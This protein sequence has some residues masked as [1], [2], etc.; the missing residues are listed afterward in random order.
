MNRDRGELSTAARYLVA[1]R[2]VDV[3][4]RPDDGNGIPLQGYAAGASRVADRAI[5]PLQL[6]AMLVEDSWNNKLLI[7]AGDVFGFSDAVVRRIRKEA[8]RWGIPPERVILNASHTHYGPGT[9]E[10]VSPGL[11]PYLPQYA[12]LI[13][14]AVSQLLP[15]LYRELAPARCFTAVADSQLGVCRRL[16][17]GDAVRMQSNPDGYYHR[18]TPILVFESLGTKA[19][20]V[21]INHGCHPTTLRAA[22]V[23]FA[24]FPYVVRS[25][26]EDRDEVERCLFLQGAAGT[27]WLRPDS[28]DGTA[29]VD[30]RLIVRASERLAEEVEAVMDAPMTEVRGPISGDLAV[31]DLPLQELPDSGRLEEWASS[32]G[33]GPGTISDARSHWAA[34]LLDSPRSE[35]PETMS[36]EVGYVEIGRQV[37]MVTMSAE[38]SA[39]LA[40]SISDALGSADPFVLGYTNGLEG[41]VT[42]AAEI[43]E[44]GYEVEEAITVYG[45]PA[46]LARES[47]SVLTGALESLKRRIDP[48]D[49]AGTEGPAVRPSRTADAF[50]CLST[51][52]CGTKTLAHVLDTA[53]NARVYHHPR[54]FLVDE[55]LDAYHGTIDRGETF[56]S[57]RKGQIEDAWA[58]DLIFGEVDHN[59]TPFVPAIAEEIPDSRFILLVRNPWD[60][61]R[62]GMRRGYYRGHPW[63]SGRLRPERDHPD[64]DRWD[65]MS[66]FEKTCWL[67]NDTYRRVLAYLDSMPESRYVFVRFEELVDDPAVA[68]RLFD[69]LGLDGFDPTA[70]E[71]ILN[72]KLNRQRTGDFPRPKDWPEEY[73]ALLRRECSDHIEALGYGEYRNQRDPVVREEGPT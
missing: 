47:E 27:S 71:R 63:D 69:T 32:V 36:L 68:R 12:D 65:D 72:R 11:G 58:D 43:D 29:P 41:Y 60:F 39:R 52:R 55:T 28:D 34:D 53:G 38:P 51:G 73:H 20:T 24:D 61:V 33:T 21:L 26:I 14:N 66:A 30:G 64:A 31:A 6:Q 49:V 35:W 57:A 2:T 17:H 48:S 19:R 22:P 44:G 9:V 70:I 5:T 50:F 8:R 67:W 25:L 3:T 56:W 62:S 1:S 45:Q 4:P 40:R 13:V 10:S 7:V 16:S 15:A 23:I 59:M 37:V 42:S 46:P 18:S 54:P